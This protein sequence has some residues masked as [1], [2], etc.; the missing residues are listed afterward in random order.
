VTPQI[1]SW[2][3]HPRR[4]ARAWLA[5]A[6]RESYSVQ[7]VAPMLDLRTADS[8]WCRNQKTRRKLLKM[9]FS[10]SQ[11]CVHRLPQT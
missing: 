10:P 4:S 5:A 9:G 1:E 2:V 3:L 11:V 6:A 7:A 8:V